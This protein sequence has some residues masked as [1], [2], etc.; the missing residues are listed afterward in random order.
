MSRL[1]RKHSMIH[2]VTIE[3][4]QYECG[5]NETICVTIKYDLK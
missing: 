5:N 3:V 4:D 1:L 2:D